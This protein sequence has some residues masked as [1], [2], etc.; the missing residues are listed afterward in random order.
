MHMDLGWIEERSFGPS[1]LESSP[2]H[3]SF[4]IPG[5]IWYL[6]ES[7]WRLSSDQPILVERYGLD[8][9]YTILRINSGIPSQ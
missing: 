2:A 9:E 7:S 8:K 5:P 6:A 4:D 3:R 1:G